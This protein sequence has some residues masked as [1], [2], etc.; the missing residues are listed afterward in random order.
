[1]DLPLLEVSHQW[2]HTLG[3]LCVWL[4]SLCGMFPEFICVVAGVSAPLLFVAE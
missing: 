1:M 4:I 3:G 2:N